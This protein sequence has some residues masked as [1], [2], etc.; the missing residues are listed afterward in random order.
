V[1]PVAI[2]WLKRNDLW[3]ENLGHFAGVT[4]W[5]VLEHLQ[6]PE[7][8]L[9]QIQLHASLFVSIPVFYALGAIRLSR[10]YRPG[11]HLQYYTEDGL[12]DWMEQHGFRV[13]ERCD[14][15]MQ[16]GRESILS[17]AFQRYRWPA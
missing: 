1:N 6:V 11:E 12:V 10:H 14:F 15:E 8:Y 16:A 9:R 13:R 5:D 4:M 17:F 2:E 3:A 7:L